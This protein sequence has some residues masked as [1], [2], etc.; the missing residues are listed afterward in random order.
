MRR[1]FLVLAFLVPA[2]ILPLGACGW[3]GG[4]S[5]D[6]P[7]TPAGP[8]LSS[9]EILN[10]DCNNENWKKQNLGLWYSVCRQPMRW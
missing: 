3:F 9:D 4:K 10:K 6:T 7:A 1:T 2:V 5:D 8:S